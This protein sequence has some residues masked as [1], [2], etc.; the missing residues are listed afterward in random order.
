MNV[1]WSKVRLAGFGVSLTVEQALQERSSAGALAEQ[2]HQLEDPA[3]PPLACRAPGAS[4]RP[5]VAA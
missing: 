4:I 3:V 1:T 2:R 5:A